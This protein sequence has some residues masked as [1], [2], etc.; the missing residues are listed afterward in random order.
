MPGVEFDTIV[1]DEA[2]QMTTAL[3]IMA[4][5]NS[6]FSI[7][8]SVYVVWLKQVGLALHHFHDHAQRFP[9]GWSGTSTATGA[10]ADDLPGWGWASELLPQVEQ[11]RRFDAAAARDAAVLMV[12]SEAQELPE[13]VMLGGV[14]YLYVSYGRIIDARLHVGMDFEML[15]KEGFRSGAFARVFWTGPCSHFSFSALIFSVD[16]LSNMIGLLRTIAL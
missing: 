4:M 15:V 2:G 3:A 12:E 10:G 1:M 5:R 16:S 14:V 11:P 9:A 6:T 8:T 7:Q 13:E